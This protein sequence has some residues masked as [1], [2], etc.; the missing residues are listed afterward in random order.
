MPPSPKKAAVEVSESMR[1]VHRTSVSDD[2]VAQL[3]DL[4]AR[5]VLKPGDR[6]PP[7]RELCKQFGVGRSSLREALRSLS[8]MGILDGRIGEGTFVCDNSQYL[9]RA[10]QWGFRLDG[11]KLQ[12]LSETRLMLESQNVFLAAERAT[13]TDLEA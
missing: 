1:P 3:T 6:L 11:K 9:E 13:E 8:V 5:N 4:I 10:L 7:E 12:D 2:I